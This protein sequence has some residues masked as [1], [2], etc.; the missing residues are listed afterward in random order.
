MTWRS[1]R[2]QL[3]SIFQVPV[4][5]Q[6]IGLLTKKALPESSIPNDGNDEQEGPSKPAYGKGKGKRKGK[7]KGKADGKYSPSSGA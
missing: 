6:T 4:H 3:A 7:G 2:R 5:N 1:Y